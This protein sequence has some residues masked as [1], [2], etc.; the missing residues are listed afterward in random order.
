M[1]GVRLVRRVVVGSV[2][3]SVYLQ[4]AS[5]GFSE[6]WLVWRVDVSKPE[7]FRRSVRREVSSE[8]LAFAVLDRASKRVGASQE[9]RREG[10]ARACHCLS[11]RSEREERGSK[12]V[13]I[14]GSSEAFPLRPQ[15]GASLGSPLAALL[16]LPRG[17]ASP[18][19]REVV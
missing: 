10:G 13:G 6:S 19:E 17:L 12:V 9:N 8:A 1:S 4:P 14:V 16:V 18:G 11:E 3:Y 5:H 2:D 7:G 15:G